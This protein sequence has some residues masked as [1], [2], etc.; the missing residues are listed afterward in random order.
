M[1]RYDLVIDTDA[2]QDVQEII[3]WYNKQAAGLGTRFHKQATLQIN[4]L[5]NSPG[6]YSIRYAD[7]RCMTIKKFPFLVHFVIDEENLRVG[8]FAVIHTSRNPKIWELKRKL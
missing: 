8:V 3:D 5:K 6:N 2:L 4:N 7:V 1:N